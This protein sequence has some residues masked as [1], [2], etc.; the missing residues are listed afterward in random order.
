MKIMLAILGNIAKAPEEAKFRSLVTSVRL[1]WGCALCGGV[2]MLIWFH[3][4][5]AFARLQE[6]PK[7]IA[8]LMSIGFEENSYGRTPF[9]LFVCSFRITS[10]ISCCSGRFAFAGPVED[11]LAALDRLQGPQPESETPLRALASQTEAV[12]RRIGQHVLHPEEVPVRLSSRV[13]IISMCY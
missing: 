1:S 11:V 12:L 10:R 2:L 4:S 6:D 5:R 9:E 3:K 13:G 8:F 7:A